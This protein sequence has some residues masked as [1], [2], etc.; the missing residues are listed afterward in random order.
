MTRDEVLAI[1]KQAEEEGWE[2]LDLRGRGLR[3]L[4]E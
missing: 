1:I 4:P 3:E 2:K